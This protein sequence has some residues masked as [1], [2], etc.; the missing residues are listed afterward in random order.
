ML[1]LKLVLLRAYPRVSLERYRVIAQ[2]VIYKIIQPATFVSIQ[3]LYAHGKGSHSNVG[4]M[5]YIVIGKALS[6]RLLDLFPGIRPMNHACSADGRE[7]GIE[8]T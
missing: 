4:R 6:N 2:S 1:L 8:C 5:T 7:H 3:N